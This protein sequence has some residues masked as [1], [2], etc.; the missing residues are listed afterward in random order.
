MFSDFYVVMI[1]IVHNKL[2]IKWTSRQLSSITIKISRS[3][4]AGSPSNATSSPSVPAN[5]FPSHKS[6]T[7]SSSMKA[8]SE[9]GEQEPSNTG[10]LWTQIDLVGLTSSQ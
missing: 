1:E 10:L 3:G 9:C 4:R 6:K 7:F 5:A 8:V 2:L